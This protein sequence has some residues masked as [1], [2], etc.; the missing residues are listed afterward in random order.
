MSYD[1]NEKLELKRFIIAIYFSKH[2]NEFNEEASISVRYSDYPF[3]KWFM[4]KR[5]YRKY[6]LVVNDST[7]T[8]SHRLSFE[9]SRHVKFLVEL[10]NK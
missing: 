5:V 10:I 4:P 3:L 1:E 7:K 8:L 6:V 9:D 2:G